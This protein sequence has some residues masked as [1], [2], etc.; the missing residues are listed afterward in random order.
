MFLVSKEQQVI[1]VVGLIKCR[2]QIATFNGLANKTCDSRYQRNKNYAELNYVNIP[3]Y[4][5]EKTDLTFR[6]L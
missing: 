3:E 6:D 5:I 1:S 4:K 2:D